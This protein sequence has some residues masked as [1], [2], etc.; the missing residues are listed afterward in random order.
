MNT[1]PPRAETLA[2]AAKKVAL[3][4][5]D[6]ESVAIAGFG[7]IIF[8]QAACRVLLRVALFLLMPLSALVLYRATRAEDRRKAQQDHQ[9]AMTAARLRTTQGEP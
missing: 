7:L 1:M 3:N 8:F 4:R 2:R 5:G 9:D 6:L